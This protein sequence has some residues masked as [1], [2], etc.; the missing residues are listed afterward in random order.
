MS[1][2]CYEKDFIQK[3]HSVSR[4]H[5]P[6]KLQILSVFHFHIMQTSSCEIDPLQTCTYDYSKS[7]IWGDQVKI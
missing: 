4:Q 5:D 1:R 3:F 2:W 6:A 7:E